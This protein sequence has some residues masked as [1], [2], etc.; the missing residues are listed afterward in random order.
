MAQG[1]QF[2]N[3]SLEEKRQFIRR[4]AAELGCRVTSAN[5]PGDNDSFHG[6]NRAIDVAGS[7]AAMTN[8]Y[9]AFVPLAR[10]RK[11]VRELFY[12]PEGGWDNFVEIGPIGGH[13]DHVHI[14][15]DPPPR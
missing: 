15:F 8:F 11:G 12:D 13:G 9:R 14:A 7:G 4:K 6:Q 10:N 5:R 3:A 1:D 2:L